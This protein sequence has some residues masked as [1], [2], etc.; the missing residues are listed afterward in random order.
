MSGAQT[1]LAASLLLSTFFPVAIGQTIASGPD[2][3]LASFS[4]DETISRRQAYPIRWSA[5]NIPPNTMLSL[6]LS[7]ITQDSRTRVGGIPQKAEMSWM[8]GGVVDSATLERL[9]AMSHSKTDYPT[10]ESGKYMWDLEKFCKQN[11]SDG[12]SVCEGAAHFR[13]QLILRTADDPCGDSL[14]CQKPR[15]LFKT[16]LSDG[17]I[18]ILD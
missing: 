7:W 10:I 4:S 3:K 5:E 8:I 14:R 13:L 15:S 9:T 17:T 2:V 1:L 11:I 16:Y 6:R 12:K 18:S